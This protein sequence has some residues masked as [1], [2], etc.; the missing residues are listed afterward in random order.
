M[1]IHIERFLEC[2]EESIAEQAS[3]EDSLHGTS[4]DS[5]HSMHSD[6][7]KLLVPNIYDIDWVEVFSLPIDMEEYEVDLAMCDALSMAEHE[8]S[9]AQVRQKLLFLPVELLA[10]YD[11]FDYRFIQALNVRECGLVMERLQEVVN[12]RETLSDQLIQCYRDVVNKTLAQ[13]FRDSTRHCD[14]LYS[15][16]NELFEHQYINAY[17]GYLKRIK[18]G[19]RLFF[20][21]NSQD[22]INNLHALSELTARFSDL[23]SDMNI[24]KHLFRQLACL[25]RND[26]NKFDIQKFTSLEQLDDYVQAQFMRQKSRKYA[27]RFLRSYMS[28]LDNEGERLFGDLQR[29]SLSDEA[30]S[31]GLSSV[32]ACQSSEDLNLLLDCLSNDIGRIYLSAKEW[33]QKDE[34]AVTVLHES[35]DQHFMAILVESHKALKDIGA[36][37]WCVTRSASYFVDYTSRKNAH[38]LVLIDRRVNALRANSVIGITMLRNGKASCIFDR[39][40]R[41]MS[42]DRINDE[43]M[44]P[45]IRAYYNFLNTEM[46]RI[47]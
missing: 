21:P 25:P 5:M 22:L 31:K 32:A 12:A 8:V 30:V 29:M 44:E 40:N 9:S 39:N 20:T 14:P 37:S 17:S 1:S 10:Q 26:Q 34:F 47:A 36:A 7:G 18:T 42:H 19:K 28:L 27:K 3:F 38:Q 15:K 11:A 45:V 16:T 46:C 6:L 23:L 24:N 33:A 13:F 35:A 4:E 2:L 41:P 43:K